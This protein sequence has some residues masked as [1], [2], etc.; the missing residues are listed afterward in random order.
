MRY[1]PEIEVVVGS[2]LEGSPHGGLV[3]LADVLPVECV[4]HPAFALLHGVDREPAADGVGNRTAHGAFELEPVEAAIVAPGITV[5]FRARAPGEYVDGTARRIAAVQRALRSLEDFD[6]IQVEEE[7]RHHRCERLVYLVQVHTHGGVVVAEGVV[8]ADAPNGVERVRASPRA[9]G[10]EA[11]RVPRQVLGVGD[12]KFLDLLATE[13]R[14]GHGDILDALLALAR[15]DNY[16]VQ[17][18]RGACLLR[19]F[20]SRN[21]DS[22]AGDRCRQQDQNLQIQC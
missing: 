20:L 11:R 7:E 10:E 13:S 12:A 14:D 17:D 19:R 16:L 1:Q 6:A 5:E 8:Q 18:S 4:V 3:Q 21:I 9:G 2:H 15:R 22:N